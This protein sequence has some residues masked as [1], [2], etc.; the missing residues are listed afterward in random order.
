MQDVFVSKV[1]RDDELQA[2]APSNLNSLSF[3]GDPAQALNR[4][5]SHS[6][7]SHYILRG[8][9]GSGTMSPWAVVV[10]HHG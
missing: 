9:S 6:S 3:R 4:A 8:S 2:G 7:T 10:Q 1:L 5:F